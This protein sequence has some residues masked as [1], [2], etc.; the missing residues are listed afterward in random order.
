V[1]LALAQLDRQGSDGIWVVNRWELTAPF[2]QA[3]PV[4]EE[5]RATERL[6][7]FLAARVAGT[8]AEGQVQLHPDTEVP[9]LYA[10]SSGAPYERYEIERAE[11]PHWPD[12]RTTFSVRL[13]ADGDTTVVEQQISWDRNQSGGLWMDA[14]TTTE[15]GQPVTLSYTSSDGELTVSAPN[16]WEA[17]L[18]GRMGVPVAEGQVLHEQALEVWSASLWRPEHFFGSGERI[19]L[20]DPV[21]YDAWCAA[22][23]GSPLLSAPADAAAIAQQLI[24]DPNFETTAPMAARIGGVEAVSIDVTLAPGGRACGV[25]MIE[26]SRW[27]HSLEPGWRLRLYLVDLPEGMSADTLAITVVAPEERFDEVIAETAPIIESI[28]FRGA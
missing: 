12:G 18:P 2:A 26:I 4:V 6:E 15:N 24:A 5:A 20:V 3:D 28:E 8:G 7:D 27:I 1:S 17:W 10:T 19:E 16:T 21:A 23:G 11:P 9:L 22:N 13:F 25:G 14:N